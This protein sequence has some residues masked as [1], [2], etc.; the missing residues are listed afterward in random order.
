[1][2]VDTRRHML[3]PLRPEAVLPHRAW[4]LPTFS[5]FWIVNKLFSLLPALYFP[6]FSHLFMPKL[7]F[8]LI[9]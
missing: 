2:G 3:E 8:I 7:D 5:H 1:V 6:T 9:I 4:F